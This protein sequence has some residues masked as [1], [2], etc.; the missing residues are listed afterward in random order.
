LPFGA[1]KQYIK[2][3]L[4][5]SGARLESLAEGKFFALDDEDQDRPPER[6]RQFIF[7]RPFLLALQQRNAEFPYFVL[8]IAN[9]ELLIPA[10]GQPPPRSRQ[11]ELVG[12]FPPSN[13][14]P[15]RQVRRRGSR[16]RELVGAFPPSNLTPARQVRR[17]EAASVSWSERSRLPT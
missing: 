7:D 12:A 13:L 9:A 10:E 17:A 2:F 3:Q 1:A 5:E 16:Q 4:D 15:A 14:T 8:W 11:R 6:P